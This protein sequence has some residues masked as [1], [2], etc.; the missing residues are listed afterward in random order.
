MGMKDEGG[1]NLKDITFFPLRKVNKVPHLCSL[2]ICQEQATWGAI[3][4]NTDK[5]VFRSYACDVHI[6]SM[7]HT[8]KEP[9]ELH[10]KYW[11]QN[12]HLH[13]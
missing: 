10:K 3:R 2:M 9:K 4:T 13:G 1:G 7:L 12:A 11:E 8:L 5:T 6:I